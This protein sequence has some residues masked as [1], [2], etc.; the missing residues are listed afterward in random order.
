MNFREEYELRLEL[1]EQLIRGFLPEEKGL[2]KNLAAAMNYSV[3]AG[4]KRL[5]PML[6]GESYSLCR[7]L[8][9]PLEAVS[10]NVVA[11]FQA[12]IEF[13]HTYSLVH[14]DLPCM[15][16]DE[17]R[18]GRPSTWK[19]YGEAL[20]VLA[21][22]SLLNYAAETTSM[23]MSL[24]RSY[25]ELTAAARAQQ[26]LFSRSGLYGMAG[27][28]T[29]DVETEG[30]SISEEELFFIQK[31]K[32]SALFEAALLVGGILG[33]AGEEELLRLEEA[34]SCLGLSFQIQD[35]LLDIHGSSEKLGKPVKSDEKNSKNTYVSV[36]GEE[37][38]RADAEANLNRAL[39]LISS[40]PERNLFL[41]ELLKSLL[42]RE[43]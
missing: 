31:G 19:A 30:K 17:L 16:N 22:D 2:R 25:G 8:T 33:G 27:G 14:D 37:K 18:R 7:G 3:L 26:I 28:Q 23:A 32:T 29:L 24:C 36:F 41:E 42:G 43:H 12:A 1:L 10:E 5:R 11:P 40:F 38:A 4:G 39:S 13:I 34:G 21:G 6:M 20:G 9:G 35:D 15:D